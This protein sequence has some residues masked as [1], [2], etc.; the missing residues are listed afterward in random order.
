MHRQ[1]QILIHSIAN[2]KNYSVNIQVVVGSQTASL[3]VIS[4]CNQGIFFQ[5]QGADAA[6]AKNWIDDADIRVRQ[7]SGDLSRWWSV[8]QDP[9]LDRFIES[10]QVQNLSLREAGFRVLS[11]R[12]QL[13]IATGYL[14]PQTQNMAGGY[15]R[16]MDSRAAGQPCPTCGIVVEKIQYLGGACYLCPRC[17]T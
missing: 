10:A 15:R 2:G 3:G 17:Q 5:F 9:V 7:E 13:G 12:A 1:P 6:V 11:A 14:F 4:N 8:F 16:L